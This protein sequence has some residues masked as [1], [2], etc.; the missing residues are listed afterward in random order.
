MCLCFTYMHCVC[1]TCVQYLWRPEG[2]GSLCTTSTLSCWAIF[3]A[4]IFLFKIPLCFCP[5]LCLCLSHMC[6]CYSHGCV[7]RCMPMCS[8]KSEINIG[9]P[10]LSLFPLFPWDRVSRSSG[11]PIT[12]SLAQDDLQILLPLT[13]KHRND[14]T[15][16]TWLPCYPQTFSCW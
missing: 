8:R 1:T 5:C 11:W 10:L 14:R 3:P 4:L 13:L 15:T 7:H 16:P 6:V 9:R 2:P 12:H